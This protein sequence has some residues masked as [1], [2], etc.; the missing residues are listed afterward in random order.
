MIEKLNHVAIVVPDLCK[1][2]LVYEG[3][4]GAKVSGVKSLPEHGVSILFVDL[5]NTKIE[6]MHPLGDG[7]P[8]STFLEKNPNGS[9]HHLCFEVHSIDEA[10]EFLTKKG[11][12]VLGDGIPKI[13]AHGKPVVFLHP[14]DFL[15]T[16]I[17]LEEI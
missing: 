8:I 2:K 9:I 12:R 1:A 11:L 17:E 4:L 16:L 14:R 10:L 7:S 15:G 5:G 3:A 6:L 13:G